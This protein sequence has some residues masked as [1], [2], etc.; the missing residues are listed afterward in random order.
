MCSGNR[1]RSRAAGRG[2]LGVVCAGL[3]LLF[4]LGTA[5][6]AWAYEQRTNTPS[7]GFQMGGGLMWGSDA[8]Q[9]SP[10]T[11]EIPYDIFRGGFGL[12]IHIR[13]SLDRRSAIGATFEDLRFR[14]K[15]GSGYP[16]DEYQVNNFL[17]RYYVY[18][19]RR[20]KISRYL[21]GGIG[22][23]RPSIRDG[24]ESSLPGEGFSA[25]LGAGLEYFLT[26]VITID[27]SIDGYML[28]P[29]GGSITAAEAKVGL[30]YYFTR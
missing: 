22:F 23:H 15:S 3:G 17:A 16:Q 5:G 19:A 27:G 24:D 2:W 1:D 18:F 30:H 8:Y 6:P 28:R 26:R 21:V 7:V 9:F 4:A 29:K 12:G 10:Q 25:N 13:Y 20:S 14:T 11:D